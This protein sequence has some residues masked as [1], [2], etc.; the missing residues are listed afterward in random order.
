MR[1]KTKRDRLVNQMNVVP[2]ID[3]MLVLLIIFMVTAPMFTPGI[4]NL[5][6]VGTAAHI[7]TTP[8]EVNIDQD[9]KYNIVQNNKTYQV[10]SLSDLVAKAKQLAANNAPVVVAADKTIQY[11]KVINVVDS[12]YSAGIKKVALVV[13]QKHD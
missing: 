7:N 2:Y 3:V 1:R 5:P 11:D 4:I 9:G 12:L 8:V 6:S 10:D 13:K